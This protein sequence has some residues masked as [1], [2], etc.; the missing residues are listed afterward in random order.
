MA[1]DVGHEVFRREV[2]YVDELFARRFGTRG[3]SVSLVNS[4]SSVDRLPLAT[5]HSIEQALQALALKMDRE[6]DLLF[7]FL[8]S[9]GS[10]DHQ[11][12]LAMKGLQLPDLPAQRLGELLKASGIRNQVIVVSACYSGGFVPALQGERTWVITAAR[13][14][15]TSFG[16]AD[17]NDF[18]YFG[19]ALFK[20]SLAGQATLGEAFAQA[21]K[22]VR[23]WEERDAAKL[24]EAAGGARAPRRRAKADSADA[25]SA[26]ASGLERSEPRSVVTPAFQAEVDAWM[27]SQAGASAP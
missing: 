5:A 10:E 21:D 7:V 8:T 16:C 25:A 13:A 14:D 11:L 22:L 17:D 12:S 4:R 27:R 18:T 9:H 19:R 26:D 2:A 15:R 24:A 20:E 3:R 6:R 1:G 23:E